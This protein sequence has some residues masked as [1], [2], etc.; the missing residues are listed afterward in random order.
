MKKALLIFAVIILAACSKK[1]EKDYVWDK[2]GEKVELS[3]VNEENIETIKISYT[4]PLR[5]DSSETLLDVLS[6]DIDRDISVNYS[7]INELFYLADK[8]QSKI[9][10]V[11]KDGGIDYIFDKKG[12]GPGEILGPA[13]IAINKNLVFIADTENY[14]VSVFDLDFNYIKSIEVTSKPNRL[15]VDSEN[16]IYVIYSL[17]LGPLVHKY[18]YEGEYLFSFGKRKPEILDKISD[19]T[20]IACDLCVND[21]DNIVLAYKHY[22]LVRYYDSKGVITKSLEGD[23]DTDGLSLESLNNGDTSRRMLLGDIGIYNNKLIAP[24][25]SP[26][27]MEG[28]DRMSFDIIDT[29]DNTA[30]NIYLDDQFYLNAVFI[31]DNKIYLF[32]FAN[33]FMISAADLPADL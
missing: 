31:I 9:I 13:D 12:A 7:D 4:G 25:V 1:T 27:S 33:L 6:T 3:S 15:D 23:M 28:E 32:D 14:R 19:P 18:S 26:K 11:S 29:E 5:T 30:A 22:Y 21:S 24:I 10:R 16:N 20:T 2:G 17:P 8:R